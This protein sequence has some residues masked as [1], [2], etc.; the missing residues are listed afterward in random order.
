VIELVYCSKCGTE[1]E[2]DALVCKNCGA[3][4]KPPAYRTYRKRRE[5]D[6]CFGTSQG[7]PIWGILFGLIIIL[8]GVT[9]LFSG[10]YWW[11]SWDKL[12][13]IFIIAIGLIIVFNALSRR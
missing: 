11:A 10:V 1:N 5:E 9:S 6:L 7:V 4:M 12:W 8:W 13:P 3:S 2:D